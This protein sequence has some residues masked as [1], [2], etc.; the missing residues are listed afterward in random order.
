MAVFCEVALPVPVDRTF[1]YAIGEGR[2]VPG[3]GARVLVPFGGQ[4][5]S[6]VVV[7]VHDRAPVEFAAKAVQQV[8]DE[9]PLLAGDLMRLAGWIAAYYVA[10]VG[11]VLRGMLPLSAEVRRHV[12][13]RLAEGGRVV[14]Y[15]GAAKGSSRRSR[16]SVEEQNREYAVL[17]YLEAGDAA[18]ASALRGAT[19]AN[20]ALLDGM[21]RKRWLTREAVAE[22]RDARRMERFAVLSEVSGA[23]AGSGGGGGFGEV[24]VGRSLEEVLESVGGGGLRLPRLNENQLA[25]MAELAAVGG[26][27]SV[28]ELRGRLAEVGVPST[29]VLTLARRG[30]V[31][32]EEVELAV[33]LGGV[34]GATWVGAHV[35]CGAGGSCFGAA[36]GDRAREFCAVSVVWGDGF[37]EDGGVSCGDTGC[38]GGGAGGDSAGAGDWADAGDGG[39]GGGGVWEGGGTAALGADGGGADAAVASDTAGR[40][41]G[42]DWDA[43][44]G[45]CAGAGFGAD[46]GG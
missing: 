22:E 26:R 40:G 3:V 32:M 13:Y 36:R 1:T 27:M 4:R 5:L 28:R 43:E 16:R 12:V 33:D 42:G 9:E 41:A 15:E 46:S 25:A 34:G 24:R 44:R 10:P 23:A 7:G 30:L 39:A 6:G 19:G 8:L 11:E 35:E 21:V 37:R 18:K 45:V 20:K 38:V 14:L 31:R 29:T 2:A 17:N